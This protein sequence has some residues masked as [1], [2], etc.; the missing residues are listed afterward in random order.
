MTDDCPVTE[1]KIT[2]VVN[3][4]LLPY[5]PP[6]CPVCQMGLVPLREVTD[7]GDARYEL[8]GKAV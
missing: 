2:H 8:T 3:G 4:S 1:V 7:D 6:F 5:Y